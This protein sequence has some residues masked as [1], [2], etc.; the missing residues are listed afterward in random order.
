MVKTNYTPE[1][2]DVL[3]C[4]KKATHS[5]ESIIKVGDMDLL[6]LDIG[7]QRLERKKWKRYMENVDILIY[8]IPLTLEEGSS[9]FQETLD[10]FKASINGE[11]FS[12]TPVLVVFNKN[13][14]EHNKD[15]ISN[16]VDMFITQLKEKR[17]YYTIGSCFTDSLYENLM[18]DM[19]DIIMGNKIEE[20]RSS[21][22]KEMGSMEN[23]KS[24][25]LSFIS[26][27]RYSLQT[28]QEKT[29]RTS[30]S[31]ANFRLS[32]GDGRLS[33][34]D[35]KSPRVSRNDVTIEITKRSPRLSKGDFLSFTNGSSP[36]SKTS[37]LHLSQD[38]QIQTVKSPKSDSESSTIEEVKA[39]SFN[40]EEKK[41]KE[42]YMTEIQKSQSLIHHDHK[43]EKKLIEKF[44]IFFSVLKKKE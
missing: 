2:E 30:K 12:K 10:D 17:L 26:P 33:Y 6:F 40:I 3:Y 18:L 43:K 9:K 28:T 37:L 29:L 31:D 8:T 27:R 4:K 39:S 16:F 7:G 5:T 14:V 15:K 41:T 32:K 19:E 44:K 38:F 20:R 13:D 1:E 23:R 35:K 24:L 34:T 11:W 22:P 21:L 36:L 42:E 25:I